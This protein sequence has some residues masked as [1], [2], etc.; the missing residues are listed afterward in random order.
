M[1]MESGKVV[2]VLSLFLTSAFSANQYSLETDF[3]D[4][5]C[6]GEISAQSY[7][8]CIDDLTCTNS[9][10]ISYS[11]TTCLNSVPTLSSLVTEW[12][13]LFYVCCSF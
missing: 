6:E 2:I 9:S 4:Y 1:R 13:V 5:S 11:E 8:E 7:Y 3:V 10:C 12:F